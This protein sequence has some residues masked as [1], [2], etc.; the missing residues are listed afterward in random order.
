[1]GKGVKIVV[2]FVVAGVT[3]VVLAVGGLVAG[4]FWLLGEVKKSLVTE[5]TFQAIRIGESR[6]QVLGKLPEDGAA[7]ELAEQAPAA[8]AGTTCEY[9]FARGGETPEGFPDPTHGY[10]FCFKGAELVAKKQFPIRK[11][12]FS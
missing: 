5:A 11:G 12:T 3:V 10:Q 7:P 2:G 9:Y 6:S 8:P 1:M 4:G